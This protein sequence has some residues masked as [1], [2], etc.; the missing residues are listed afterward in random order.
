MAQEPLNSPNNTNLP[1]G[2]SL[3]FRRDFAGT[4]R[5][6]GSIVVDGV[7]I[8]P[9][10]LDHLSYRNGIR[11]LRT[12]LLTQKAGSITFSVEEP[13]IL[14]LQRV[15]F[16]GDI[17][18]GETEVLFEGRQVAL[19]EDSNGLYIDFAEMDPDATPANSTVIGVFELTDPLEEFGLS[20]S[21]A[22]P[23]AQNKVYV[24][25]TTETVAVVG[26]TVYVKYEISE[27]GLYKTQL[28]GS[29]KTKVEGDAQLQARNQDGGIMMIWDF[30][31]LSLSPN[32]EMP[33]AADA[34]QTIPVLG[35]LQE[36]GGTFGNIL[37]K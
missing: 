5:E 32:G 22:V 24:V 16:G 23:D 11:S 14:N 20:I 15:F 1:H 8:N 25:N 13:S 6:F 17:T 7:T 18:Q 2:V 29:D 3:W 27:T 35:T 34:I 28:Y 26:D 19:K 33:L 10:F 9:E 4:R 12:R 30:A 37:T 31:S 21:N 36:R